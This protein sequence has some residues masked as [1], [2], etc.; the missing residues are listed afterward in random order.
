MSDPMAATGLGGHAATGIYAV[1]PHL[2]GGLNAASA[3]LLVLGVVLVKQ[4]KVEAH[5]ACM[6]LAFCLSVVFLASY[7]TLHA[8]V[9]ATTFRGEGAVRV[10]YFTV[11]IT[12]MILAAT[13]PFLAVRTIYLARKGRIEEHKRIAKVA[14]PVWLY[15]S[16]TGVIVYMFLYHWYPP[17]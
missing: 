12:H 7:L 11:L 3:C 16:V 14:F 2:N 17:V 10:T 5:K 9:G 13:V 15:V 8:E 4:G 6:G 1:L